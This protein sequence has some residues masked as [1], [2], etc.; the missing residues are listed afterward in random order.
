MLLRY[1]LEVTGVS[2]DA[3]GHFL[4]NEIYPHA[5]EVLMTTAEKLREEGFR[6]GIEQGLERGIEQGRREILARLLGLRFG[7][8][9]AAEWSRLEQAD[10]AHL[11]L[12]SE[13]ILTATSVAEVLAESSD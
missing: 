8:L 12:W 9:S 7:P 3:L 5:I 2:P 11:N 13:R 4:K 1:T 10:A 6:R